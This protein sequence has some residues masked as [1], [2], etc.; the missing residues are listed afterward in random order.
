MSSLVRRNMWMW[1]IFNEQILEN[2]WSLVIFLTMII[3]RHK[4]DIGNMLAQ[5]YW[6]Y[7]G[8][9]TISIVISKLNHKEKQVFSNTFLIGIKLKISTEN[10]CTK[11]SYFCILTIMSRYWK[12]DSVR[13]CSYTMVILIWMILKS[14][15]KFSQTK[16]EILIG[17]V[18]YTAKMWFTIRI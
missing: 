6:F 2:A 3:I 18:Y 5:H 9:L 7:D 4:V 11:I 8:Y 13:V 17:A 10:L 14:W 15:W 12:F 1:I 16:F